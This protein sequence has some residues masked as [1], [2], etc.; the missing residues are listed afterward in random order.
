MPAARPILRAGLTGGI[1][2]DKTTVAG[3]FAEAGAFVLDADRIVHE[4]LEPQGAAYG[5]VVARFGTRIL[6]SEGRIARSVLGGVVFGDPRDRAALNAI[7]HPRV[8][9]E[10]AVRIANH[11]VSGSSR[12]AVIDAAL[13][14]EAGVHRSLD[15]LV[16]VRCSR[17]TQMQRL[18]AR[19]T[20]RREEAESRLDSQAGLEQ[21]LAV[22]DYVIDTETTIDRTRARTLEVYAALV[23]DFESRFPSGVRSE[24]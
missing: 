23:S 20:L 13:L 9:D 2:S 15:R 7:V 24:S 14:V 16:V 1:A 22:A 10:I 4:L 5:E 18:L 8:M 6:D 19:G 17:A 21:K 11:A 3:F 12:I